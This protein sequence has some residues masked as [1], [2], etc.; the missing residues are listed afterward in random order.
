MTKVEQLEA[1]VRK[2]DRI[3]LAVFRQWFQEYDGDEWDRQIEED[4]QAGKLDKLV[5]EALAQHRTGQT[6]E[7]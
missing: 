6:K 3:E 2:L 7:L 4:I 1:E 5:E